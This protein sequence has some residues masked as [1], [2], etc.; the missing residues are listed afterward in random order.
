MKRHRHEQL[1]DEAIDAYVD[2]REE[3]AEVWDAYERW[4][5]APAADA[6]SAFSAY[7]AAV[8]RED[9][10]SHV[11]AELMTRAAAPG[12]HCPSGT[13]LSRWVD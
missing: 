8:D 4:R 2:W 10:A 3:S 11:Y 7:C 9:R 6:P 5:H 1:L 13:G 12:H